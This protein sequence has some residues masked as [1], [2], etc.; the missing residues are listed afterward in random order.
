MLIKSVSKSLTALP[1]ILLM[2]SPAS[3][4]P[5]VIGFDFME[6]FYVVGADNRT[7]AAPNKT[8]HRRRHKS[9]GHVPSG[10]KRHIPSGRKKWMLIALRQTEELAVEPWH[11]RRT[12]RISSSGRGDRPNARKR[13]RYTKRTRH[14]TRT[15]ALSPSMA[16]AA[17]TKPRLVRRGRAQISCFPGRLK[18]I[19]GRVARR[20]GRPVYVLSG[21]RSRRHNRRVGG[22]RRSYHLKCMAADIAVPKVNKYKLARFLKNIPGR[23]GVGTYACS[24]YVHI[25]VGPRRAW[26]WGCRRH[27]YRKFARLHKR[28]RGV[29]VSHKRAGTF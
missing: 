22:A 13:R 10:R 25:D 29:R 21:Y 20:F 4:L 3:A 2:S 8:V 28:R 7:A 16:K 18:S 19:L 6:K 12:K 1:L 27:G 11:G 14:R 26:H 24:G 5:D 9:R 23:G 15:A 17:F